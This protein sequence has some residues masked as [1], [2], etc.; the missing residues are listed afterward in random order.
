M[1][2]RAALLT[3]AVFLG[4]AGFL[5]VVIGIGAMRLSASRD[6]AEGV[7][8]LQASPASR[9]AAA[10]RSGSASTQP[11]PAD[12]TS[13]TAEPVFAVDLPRRD[14]PVSL[15]ASKALL[16]GKAIKVHNRRRRGDS[17]VASWHAREDYAEWSAVIPRAGGYAVELT[18]ACDEGAGGRFELVVGDRAIA[19][20]SEQTGEGGSMVSLGALELPAGQTRVLLR[21]AG[22]IEG[23][24]MKLRR[25]DLFPLDAGAFAL[26]RKADARRL[27]PPGSVV[28]LPAASAKLSGDELR[29]EG[30]RQDVAYWYRP[31]DTVEWEFDSP[32]GAFHVDLTF[33]CEHAQ[34]RRFA[35]SVA[36]QQLR[37]RTT[38]TGGWEDYD[39]TRLGT[40]NL[41][42]GPARLA[43]RCT[44]HALD[45]A[46]MNVR[47]VELVRVDPAQPGAAV[48]ANAAGPDEA[49][50]RGDGEQP[51]ASPVAAALAEPVFLPATLAALHGS[52]IRL[53]PVDGDE[54]ERAV[55]FWR[56]PEEHVEWLVHLDRAARYHVILAYACAPGHG[57]DFT[58]TASGQSLGGRVK[59]EGTWDDRRSLHLGTV[60]LAAGDTPLLL[61]P[62]R[63]MPDGRALMRCRGLLLLPAGE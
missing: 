54:N 8:T 43:I 34:P 2:V 63:P 32:G 61:K 42:P 23:E 58:L 4:L 38:S 40:V 17:F 20:R 39:T 27:P 56:D 45:A 15:T 13:S 1:N 46:L 53:E 25:V 59:G 31:E 62:A 6:D 41:P 21:P 10:R 44:E 16:H 18:Y 49:G 3:L 29:R 7:A 33:A 37:G 12:P 30:E 51:S 48:A 11:A 5:A 60:A 22:R 35:V 57:G 19:G 47:R 26:A 24:L 36:G 28:T 14:G 55:G 9:P 50:G 52:E